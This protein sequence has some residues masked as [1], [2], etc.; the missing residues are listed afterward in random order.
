M[1]TALV[2]GTKLNEFRQSDSR[3]D[4]P[5][6]ETSASRRGTCNLSLGVQ[7]FIGSSG[8]LD[9]EPRLVREAILRR[10]RARAREIE[11]FVQIN[12]LL[13]WKDSKFIRYLKEAVFVIVEERLAIES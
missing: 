13:S 5:C 11:P 7:A 8:D 3:A 1:T 9:G 12:F 2:P 10:A 4:V 6:D